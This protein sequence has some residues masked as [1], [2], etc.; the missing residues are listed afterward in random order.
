MGQLATRKRRIPMWDNARFLCVTLVVIGHGIQR[1]TADSDAALVLYLFIYAFHMPA[2]AI[3]SGYFSKASPPTS[4]RMKKILTDILLP[5]FIMETIWS[6]VQFFVEGRQDFNPSKP[7]LDALVSARPRN[8]PADSA[9]PGADA[10][11]ARLGRS[12]SRSESAT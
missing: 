3:I 10:L 7:S 4:R 1:L 12:P 2:F 9:L 5:Y 6:L 11:A 8:L